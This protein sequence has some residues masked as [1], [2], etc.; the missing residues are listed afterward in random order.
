MC[1]FCSMLSGQKIPSEAV[2]RALVP[3]RS[4]TCTPKASTPTGLEPQINFRLCLRE[5]RTSDLR[6]AGKG[7]HGWVL[8]N[9]YASPQAHPVVG[10]RVSCVRLPG[11]WTR[12]RLLR[13]SSATEASLHVRSS[14]VKIHMRTSFHTLWKSQVHSNS[15]IPEL[16]LSSATFVR[17]LQAFIF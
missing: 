1:L 12:P 2:Q 15:D 3:D 9:V 17:L 13:G 11:S 5:E 8:Y 6:A 7:W 14:Y 4:P 10:R 16:H